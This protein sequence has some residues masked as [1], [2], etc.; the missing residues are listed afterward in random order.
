MTLNKD[1]VKIKANILKRINEHANI[2]LLKK[3]SEVIGYLIGSFKK[4]YVE[5]DDIVIPEQ[6]STNI[7]AEITDERALID[8]LEKHKM[9][10]VQVGWYHS[11]PNLGCFLSNIDILTQKYWQKINNRMVALVIDPTTKEIKIFRLD[12]K[13]QPYEISFKKIN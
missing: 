12:E 3:S 4:D 5:I 10:K 1:I 7:H 9:K 6:K 8:Y 11:H 13:Y 2:G